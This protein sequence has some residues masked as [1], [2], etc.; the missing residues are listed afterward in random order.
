VRTHAVPGGV[1]T[2]AWN[3]CAG[4]LPWGQPTD[5]RFDDA[6][7]LTWDWPV[8]NDLELL[9]RPV[10]RLRVAADQPVAS[11]SAKL[12]EVAPDGTSALITRGLLN[13]THRA[14]SG[15]PAPLTPGE[16]VDATVELETTAWTVARG[17]TLR[18][19]VTGMDWPNTVAPPQPLTLLVDG[20]SSA[21]TLPLCEGEPL[22]PPALPWLPPPEPADTT[23]IWRVSDDVLRRHTTVDTA[24]GEEYEARG[25]TCTDRYVGSVGIDRRTWEQWARGEASFELRSPLTSVRAESTIDIAIDA[26]RFDLTITLRAYE[27]DEPVFERS[28]RREYPRQLG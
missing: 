13:L 15:E 4:A 26:D 10:L 19:A 25:G 27:K 22:A 9:G 23:A 17:H 21:L 7:S 11:V 8:D 5:Q 16:Y 3:S 24:Y 12:C 2:A 18:L 20:D 1:G 28:W 6:A 14:G